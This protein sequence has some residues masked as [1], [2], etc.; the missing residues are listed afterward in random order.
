MALPSCDDGVERIVQEFDKNGTDLDK[1]C[2]KYILEEEAGSSTR[3]FDNGGLRM[4]C[5]PRSDAYPEGKILP[6][7]LVNGRGMVLADF[8]N[9]REAQEA[10]LAKPHVVGLR[11]YSTQIFASLNKP[12]RQSFATK[13]EETGLVQ[14]RASTHRPTYAFPVTMSFIDEAIKKLRTVHDGKPLDLYARRIEH[15]ASF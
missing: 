7:R 14:V 9:S 15:C 10:H 4:D 8:L 12:L 2:L 13:D 11:A 6:E 3:V 1:E 5:S